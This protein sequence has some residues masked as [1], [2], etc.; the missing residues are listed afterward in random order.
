MSAN[1]DRF[2]IHPPKKVNGGLR[3]ALFGSLS[4]DPEHRGVWKAIEADIRHNT[5]RGVLVVNP[6]DGASIFSKQKRYSKGAATLYRRGMT[7]HV[8]AGTNIARLDDSL[9]K[10]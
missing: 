6:R 10:A 2:T 3:E 7:L 8:F 9:G 1:H 5:T 4:I